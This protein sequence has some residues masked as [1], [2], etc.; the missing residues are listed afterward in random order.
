MHPSLKRQL[1]R[2]GLSGGEAP[3][4]E[5][6]AALLE[7]VSRTYEDSDQDRYTLERSLSISSTEMQRLYEDLKR[8]SATEL[9]RSFAVLDATLEAAEDGILVVDDGGAVIRANRRCT[10][11]WNLPRVDVESFDHGA[12]VRVMSALAADPVAFVALVESVAANPSATTIDEVS[13]HDGRILGRYSMPIGP[14]EGTTPGRVWFFRDVTLARHGE[15]ELRT[16]KEVAEAASRAK[17]EFLAN[18][19]HELRTPLNAIVGFS[20]L[21]SNCVHGPLNDKQA[22]QVGH[23]YD[24]G[25]HLLLLINEILDLSRI[26]AG[27]MSLVLSR[28][29]VVGAVENALASMQPLADAKQIE[30]GREL[31]GVGAVGAA[32]VIADEAKFQNILLNLLSN[33]VKF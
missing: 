28:F 17:S 6:W 18:M 30:M 1:K 9:R 7:R 23:I 3:P 8:T 27:K 25:R 24:G 22:K 26:E 15:T 14:V 31:C 16:A 19:S 29:D 5:A 2:L 4:P 10:E 33:A 13:L 32:L 20:E 11:I 12:L 21:L